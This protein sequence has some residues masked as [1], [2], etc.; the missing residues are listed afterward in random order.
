MYLPLF[1]FSPLSKGSKHIVSCCV[2]QEMPALTHTHKLEQGVQ[3]D[4][5]R[6]NQSPLSDSLSK[7]QSVIAAVLVPESEEESS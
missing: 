2:S 1:H 5:C 6:P 4:A 7:C 3:S